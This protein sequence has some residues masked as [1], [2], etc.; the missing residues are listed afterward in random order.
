MAKA[1]A[2]GKP[3][4]LPVD[5]AV[6]EKFAADAERTIT[7]PDAVP[8]GWRILDIGP[9]TILAFGEALVDAQTIIWNGTLGVAEFPAFALGTR[10]ADPPAGG[11]HR[12]GRDD[13]R[14]RR[15]LGGGGRGGRARLTSSRT[16]RPAAAPRWSSW[17]GASCPASRRCATVRPSDD[18]TRR[19]KG[20]SEWRHGTPIVAGN[21]KMNYG[22]SRG[23]RVRARYPGRSA[24]RSAR[25]EK[26]LCPPAISIPCGADAHRWHARSSS[27]RRTC[28]SRRRAPITG[29]ISPLMLQGLCEYVILGHSERRALLR[30]DR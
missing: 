13:D 24:R 28:T 6:G 17:R 8:E 11:A 27:A 5:V 29:E 9:Q 14:R 18:P 15:R 2:A 22:P 26:V 20:C 3:F 1:E 21:W 7:T 16:S 12:R 30:R 10:R 4:V 23:A 19:V 25:V